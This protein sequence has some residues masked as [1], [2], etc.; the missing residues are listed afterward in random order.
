MTAPEILQLAT[1]VATVQILC[2]LIS[3]WRIFSREPYQ[4]ALGAL[5]RSKNKLARE[6]AAVAAK[7]EAAASST[8]ST[9]KKGASSKAEKL[10][11]RLERVEA[12]HAD[13]VGAVARRHMVPNVLTSLVF[14]ILLRILGLEHKGHIIGILPFTPFSLAQR[15][16]LRGLE[17]GDLQF[18]PLDSSGKVTSTAQATSFIFIYFLCTFSVKYYASRLFGTRPPPG[19]ESA[20]SVIET[21][22]GQ[23]MMKYMG[24][25]PKDLK[26]E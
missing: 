1:T 22:Q 15:L 17:F 25:D 10:A 4:R 6:K 12:D 23:K 11:K 3:N 21:S 19:A 16:T 2:D 5:E 20:L 8:T 14:F 24:V 26:M 18:E 13:A 7:Q 9:T